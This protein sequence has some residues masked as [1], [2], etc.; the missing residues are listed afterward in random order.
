MQSKKVQE[1]RL[2]FCRKKK[3]NNNGSV[4]ND[5]SHKRCSLMGLILHMP[6][7][8]YLKVYSY[9]DWYSYLAPNWHNF[10]YFAAK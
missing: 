9:N 10:K 6:G 8:R 5:K 1:R 2:A 3:I 7:V 4:G